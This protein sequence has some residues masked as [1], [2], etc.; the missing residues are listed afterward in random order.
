MATVA[1]GDT[2]V[3]MS[4]NALADVERVCEYVVILVDGQVRLA[5]DLDQLTAQHTFVSGPID[6]PPF[7][8]RWQV[9]DERHAER[10]GTW[11]LHSVGDTR[12]V[13]TGDG[14]LTRQATLEEI[15]LAY[16]RS[17]EK[18]APS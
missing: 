2:S 16:L 12:P 3:V 15:V 17:A 8:D 9:I 11:L 1:D 10:Q 4:A 13:D 5:G 18:G 7:G 14:T 6:R